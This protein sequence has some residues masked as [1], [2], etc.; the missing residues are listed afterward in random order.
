M[1]GP[2]TAAASRSPWYWI[3]AGAAAFGAYACMY[4][5]RKPFTVGKFADTRF[6]EG[7][8]DWLVVAQVLGY[9]CSKII[10]IRFIAE[11]PPARRATVFLALIAA[12]ELALVLFAVAPAPL[13]ALC[14]FLNGLPLGLVFGLVLGFLEGRRLTEAF[15]AGLCTSFILADGFVKS[16]GAW[17]LTLGV[18]ER[19]MPA[20]TGALFVLPLVACVAVLR[21]IPPPSAADI[22][23]RTE[24]V[25]TTRDERRSLL[26]R[27]A[28]GLFLITTAYL[29]VTV[30]RSLR[31]DFAPE[32]WAGLGFKDRP[33]IFTQS[34]LWVGL[35]VLV[36]NGFGAVIR[37]NLRAFRFA[38]WVSVLGLALGAL[39]VIGQR[40]GQLT[41]FPFMVLLGLGM[42]LPYV[43]VHTTVFERWIALSR[44][45]GNLGFLMYLAD[46]T[47][48][49][50][51][52]CVLIGR[53]LW[54][55]DSDFLG[56]FTGLSGC[57]AAA[58][59]VAMIVGGAYLSRGHRSS[60]AP[61][62]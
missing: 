47:G 21:R 39:A 15:V 55:G 35:G 34:E 32:I 13:D 1:T 9:T 28:P 57:L 2:R 52:A 5:F 58:A 18:P 54:R 26:Q 31:A 42:Y 10:G 3:A 51:Y 19:W 33:A 25:P 45:R 48:Y 24:R 14:L 30:I 36:V 29:L 49:V 50:G 41:G 40:T 44:E 38:L 27:H 7:Y 61:R 46:A 22:A 11:L 60:A 56:F 59:A 53:R 17:V 4:A 43:A 16:A 12:A 23:E 62:P 6:H 37:D 8:K 20:A